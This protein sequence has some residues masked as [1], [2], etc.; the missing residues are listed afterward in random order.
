MKEV[1]RKHVNESS[2]GSND[3][4]QRKIIKTP[5]DLASEKLTKPKVGSTSN[6]LQL[7]Y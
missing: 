5:F 6:F 7:Q 2:S 1:K 3:V 4:V